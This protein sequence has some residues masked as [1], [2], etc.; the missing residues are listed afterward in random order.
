MK[1]VKEVKAVKLQKINLQKQ[2]HKNGL[3]TNLENK[4]RKQT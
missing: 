1:H 2:T 3:I 4:L